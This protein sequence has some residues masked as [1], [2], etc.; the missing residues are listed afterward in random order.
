MDIEHF[1]KERIKFTKYFYE[2]GCL[3]FERIIDLIEKEQPPYVPVYDESGEPQFIFDWLQARDGVESIGL[4]AVSMFSSSLQIYMNAWLDRFEVPLD[5]RGG[6]K[7]WFNALKREMASC[8]VDFNSCDLDLDVLEQL[9]LARNRIQHADD[10]TSNT[11]DHLPKELARFPSPTFVEPS[12][13]GSTNTWF[14]YPRVYID[15]TKVDETA[16]L[17]ESFCEWLEAE[18]VR[19]EQDRVRKKQKV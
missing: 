16:S 17:I 18:F 3:P 7:G 4:A 6:K 2:N 12:Y 8:G 10:I 19:L 15:Q 5:E 11:V 13:L 14:S 9:V 1:T